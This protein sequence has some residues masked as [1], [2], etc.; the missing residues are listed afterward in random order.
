MNKTVP[1]FKK[2][3]RLALL[4]VCLSTVHVQSF[5]YSQTEKIDVSI[6]AGKLEDV[7]QT[8]NENSKYKMFFSKAILPNSTIL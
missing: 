3:S 1:K 8:I 4:L 2:E 5:A 6:K 7:F